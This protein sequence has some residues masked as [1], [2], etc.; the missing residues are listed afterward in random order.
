MG[1]QSKFLSKAG[2]L[3]LVKSVAQA[4][5]TYTMHVFQLPKGVLK[6]FQSKIT[7]FWWGKG[8]GKKGLHYCKWERLCAS[9]WSGGL[10]FRDLEMFNKALV[11]K[12]FWRL[13]HNPSSLVS[14]LLQAKYFHAM[15]WKAARKGRGG[16]MIWNSLMWGKELLE[17]GIRWRVGD[18]RLISVKKDR[19]LPRP[20]SFKVFSPLRSTE[21]MMIAD[22]IV[23]NEWD[24]AKVKTLFLEEEAR[25]I[26][27]LNSFVS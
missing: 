3:T 20:L 5:P 9:K 12:T 18:G 16:S 11:A 2:K 22:L 1:W 8:G 27:S 6:A 25:V 26:Y 24:V 4:I 14:R 10:G 21:E 15:D 19:W 17:L 13:M 23:Q 7:K